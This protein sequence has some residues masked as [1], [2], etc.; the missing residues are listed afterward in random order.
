MGGQTELSRW[1]DG[2]TAWIQ[3]PGA[4]TAGGTGFF[5]APG[6]VLTCAHVLGRADRVT[7]GEQVTVRWGQAPY[8]AKVVAA[9]PADK[10]TGTVWAPPDL[11]VVRLEDPPAGHPCAWLDET[12]IELEAH[13]Y[14]PG[15]STTYSRRPELGGVT[16]RYTG[17]QRLGGYELARMKDDEL[18]EGMSG[19]PVLD[20]ARGSVCGVVK[21]ARRPGT[22]L[23]GLAIP[24][25]IIRTA[26]PWIWD[27]NAA[28]RAGDGIWRR[29]QEAA[30][31]DQAG[32]GL[33]T[34]A[35]M[36]AMERAWA[37]L[38]IP[39]DSLF[40]RMFDG[41]RPW[42]ESGLA[43]IGD[44]VREA[45][46][47]VA[48]LPG[49]P[50]P[51]LVLLDILAEAAH[52]RKRLR[53]ISRRVAAPLGI[54]APIR[55]RAAAGRTAAGRPAGRDR[56]AAIEILIRRHGANRRRY[57]LI[58]RIFH[59]LAE[60][61]EVSQADDE[62]LTL[63]K[64]Q[65]Q[66]GRLLPGYLQALGSQDRDISIEFTLPIGL[67]GQ[68]V[69]EWHAG[70]SWAPLGLEF[71]VVLRVSDRDQASIPAWRRKWQTLHAGKATGPHWVDC[72]A[73]GNK[74]QLLAEFSAD[75]E[76]VL[77]LTYRPDNARGR[78]VL[79]A[80]LRAGVPAAIWPASRCPEHQPGQHGANC[81]GDEFR[82]SIS[83]R[84]SRDRLTDLPHLVKELRTEAEAGGEH[85]GRGLA[86]LWDDPDRLY[87][88]DETPLAG[89]Q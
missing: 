21:T 40:A 84:I 59:D 28:Y 19:G 76:S 35:D 83:A 88:I 3:L 6:L 37:E 45:A 1:L 89:P 30:R 42:P 64:I 5:V 55:P 69:E 39:V 72:R 63:A 17:P 9:E 73:N 41:L 11:A 29:L 52:G 13:L 14:V 62:P 66:V 60:P 31:H 15:F 25:K 47:T 50:H 12:P 33:L 10:G 44:L 71:P 77:A 70:T 74:R 23:G 26:L 54:E 65:G 56:M 67:I 53:K 57:L 46:D 82:T 49:E 85:P 36:A 22:S 51:L 27:A 20:I 7:I 80:A 43:D 61:P 81:A 58:T 24:A 75:P 34:T 4:G 86:L 38:G 48:P 18:A 79:E 32:T 68:Q 8:V 78:D 16:T 87:Q 2:C